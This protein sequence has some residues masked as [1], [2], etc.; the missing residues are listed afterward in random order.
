MLEV[1]RK[2]SEKKY[3]TENTAVMTDEL[4]CQVM[5]S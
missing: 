1:A 4:M 5:L 3:K 2:I